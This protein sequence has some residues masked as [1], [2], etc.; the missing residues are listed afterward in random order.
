MPCP[1]RPAPTTAMRAL[2]MALPGRV[3]AVGVEDMAGVEIRR[4]RRQEQER[5]RK[6]GRLAEA[7]LGD[8]RHEIFPHLLGIVVVLEHPL[9]QRRAEFGR[10]SCRGSDWR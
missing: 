8:A 6:I 4:L 3:A 2:A 1:M 9:C 7:A 5:P 10:A